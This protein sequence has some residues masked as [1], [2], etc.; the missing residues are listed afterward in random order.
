[1]KYHNFLTIRQCRPSDQHALHHVCTS[2]CLTM[3]ITCFMKI[4]IM[5]INAKKTIRTKKATLKGAFTLQISCQGKSETS[6]SLNAVQYKQTQKHPFLLNFQN[7]LS[8]TSTLIWV[9][10]ITSKKLMNDSSSN[11]KH[12]LQKLNSNALN[13]LSSLYTCRPQHFYSQ[14]AEIVQGIRTVGQSWRT[15]YNDSF[16]IPKP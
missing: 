1:M 4:S 15:N 8:F 2:Y 10:Y 13:H 5:S 7:T 14:Q 12:A 3:N 6:F 11:P 9:E 16:A